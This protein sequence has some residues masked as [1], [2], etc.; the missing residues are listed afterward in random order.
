MEIFQIVA[1]GFVASVIIVLIRQSHAASLATLLSI[2]VGVGIFTVMVPKIALVMNLLQELSNRAHINQFY[3]TT[4]LRIIGIAYIAEFGAQVCRDA[5][6]SAVA[7]RVEFAGKVLIMVLAVPIIVAI[8][9]TILRM[10][11]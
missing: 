4:L 8:L 11:S 2:L 6:E 1:I 5:G 7:S 10:L 3:L 9:E